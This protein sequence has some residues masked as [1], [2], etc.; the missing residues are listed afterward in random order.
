MRYIGFDTVYGAP[1]ETSPNQ[2]TTSLPPTGRPFPITNRTWLQTLVDKFLAAAPF[3]QL[4]WPVP[5]GRAP[6]RANRTHT[7]NL[8]RFV[9]LDTFFGAPGETSPSQG[10]TSLPPTGRPHPVGERTW[11]QDLARRL[12]D[13]LPFNQY[14]WPVPRG[15][16]FPVGPRTATGRLGQH[17][18]PLAPTHWTTGAPSV[19][20]TITQASVQGQLT[21]TS[22]PTG[23]VRS[24]RITIDE[25]VPATVRGEPSR[26]TTLTED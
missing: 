3:V 16:P 9:G 21:R 22:G 25:P 10:S 23:A 26:I 15:W 8:T 17:A 6:H 7:T 4:D 20:G 14:T 18:G 1:G 19:Q 11:I 2:G 24:V 13:V 5:W 12:Y